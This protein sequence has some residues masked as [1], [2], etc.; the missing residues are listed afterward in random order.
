MSDDNSVSRRDAL[1][2]LAIGLS[3]PV[4]NT[5]ALAQQ[6]HSHEGHGA[7]TQTAEV[8]AGPPKF[9]NAQQMTL[10]ATIS[11]LIIP[12]DDHS[13]GAIAAEVPSFTDLMVSESPAETK[14]LWT[15]GLAAVDALSRNKNQA[16]FDKATAAQQ[17]ALLSEISK[18]EKSPQTLEERFFRAIK[19]M[20]IDGY[21]TSKVGIHQ[22]LQY[23]GNTYLK[24]FKG[25]THPEHING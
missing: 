19:N 18:N 22:D 20:T 5:N 3:L 14:K 8:K 11:E 24:E 25:C 4:L 9:F 1:K 7:S 17:I 21:Y 13:P 10:I 15:D 6:G 2:G 23:K 16:A 12:T